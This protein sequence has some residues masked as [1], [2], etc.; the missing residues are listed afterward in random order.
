MN[1]QGGSY[2]LATLVILLAI[3]IALMYS[4]RFID[5][6]PFSGRTELL[7]SVLKGVLRAE[8]S[9]RTKEAFE[10][11]KEYMMDYEIERSAS[12]IVEENLKKNHFLDDEK[13]GSAHYF[14]ES[15]YS[16]SVNKLHEDREKLKYNNMDGASIQGRILVNLTYFNITLEYDL[17]DPVLGGLNSA[18]SY[19]IELSEISRSGLTR[20]SGTVLYR[21]DLDFALK[22]TDGPVKYVRYTVYV[23]N[24]KQLEEVAYGF[25]ESDNGYYKLSVLIRPEYY[26]MLEKDKPYSEIGIVLVVSG[27]RGETLWAVIRVN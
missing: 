24:D 1:K 10:H 14:M 16:I 22:D 26:I 6:P 23:L 15:V 18:K 19:W 11:F 2:I 21:L 17:T 8:F 7:E 12:E 13:P 5:E 3:I 4:P 25:K 27:S 9:T 20:A